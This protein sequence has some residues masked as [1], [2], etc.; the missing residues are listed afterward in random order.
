[1]SKDK[2]FA[3]GSEEHKAFLRDIGLKGGNSTKRNQLAK[4]PYYYEELGRRGGQARIANVGGIE[5]F[6][7]VAR[8][9][10]RKSG[11]R[12]SEEDE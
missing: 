2:K 10:G 11:K 5:A 6:R 3:R 7:E 1:M 8:E 12:W 4:N 9:M